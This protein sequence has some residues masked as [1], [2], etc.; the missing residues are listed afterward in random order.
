VNP[1][2]TNT[3]KR[4]LVTKALLNYRE[5]LGKLNELE[6]LVVTLAGHP[7]ADDKDTA[8]AA[9]TLAK[10]RAKTR[11]MRRQLQDAAQK[12]GSFNQ[13]CWLDRN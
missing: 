2:L 11:K 9:L 10:H 13:R 7:D 3:Q 8:E 6:N 5:L 4:E 12:Y 1:D